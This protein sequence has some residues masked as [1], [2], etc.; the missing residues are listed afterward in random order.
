MPKRILIAAGLG[1]LS[2]IPVMLVFVV[3]SNLTG[4]YSSSTNWGEVFLVSVTVG[5]AIA[6]PAMLFLGLPTALVLER[7]GYL[8]VFTVIGAAVAYSLL[9]AFLLGPNAGLLLVILCCSLVV[10]ISSYVISNYRRG[11]P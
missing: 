3:A 1:P 8:N 10:A 11:L 9:I 5:L 4:S 7:I 2:V 6:Y